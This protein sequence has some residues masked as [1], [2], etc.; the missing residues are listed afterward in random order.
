MQQVIDRPGMIQLETQEVDGRAA[1]TWIW[2]ASRVIWT[3]HHSA[4]RTWA[5][6]EAQEASVLKPQ[7]SMAEPLKVST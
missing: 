3:Y 4:I 6:L 2:V 1:V 5:F 7:Q